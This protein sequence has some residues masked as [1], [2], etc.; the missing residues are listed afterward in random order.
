MQVQNQHA[1]IKKIIP[2]ESQPKQKKYLGN[3]V[4]KELKVLYTENYK[5]L[6]KEIE[7]DTI[8][9]KIHCAHGLRRINII[10]MSILPKLM[11]RLITLC[12]ISIKFQGHFFTE[13]IK[14]LK[15]IGNHRRPWTAETTRKK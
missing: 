7:E 14:P 10:E 1:E 15:F 9:G 8:N 3:R 11:Y 4:T 2:L 13:K 5:T 12:V 6:L